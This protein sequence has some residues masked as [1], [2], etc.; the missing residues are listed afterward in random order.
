MIIIY[1]MI[2]GITDSTICNMD[3]LGPTDSVVGAL[4]FHVYLISSSI[5]AYIL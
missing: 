3:I 2:H 1:H 4:I 5:S